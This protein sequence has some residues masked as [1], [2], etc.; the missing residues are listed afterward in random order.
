VSS[1]AN[2]KAVGSNSR[3]LIT[4]IIPDEKPTPIGIERL[5]PFR[6]I[7]KR[8]PMTV[9]EPERKLIRSITDVSCNCFHPY[10]KLLF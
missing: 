9:V 7:A 3:K 1:P 6:K 5:S 10:S 2:V 4:I 8:A